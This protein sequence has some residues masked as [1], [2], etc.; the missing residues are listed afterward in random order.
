MRKDLCSL[1]FFLWLRDML[2]EIMKGSPLEKMDVKCLQG[3]KRISTTCAPIVPC[4]VIHA[5]RRPLGP[6][7]VAAAEAVAQ[8]VASA[9]EK[10]KRMRHSATPTWKWLEIATNRKLPSRLKQAKQIAAALP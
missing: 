2:T 4:G 10:K 5:E 8:A 3:W 1:N 9:A 6:A 7:T